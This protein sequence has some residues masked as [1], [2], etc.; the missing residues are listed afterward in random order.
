MTIV[1]AIVAL[2]I[3]VASLAF[4]IFQYRILHRVR[5]AEKATS[6]LRLVQ[7]L[8]RKSEDLRH[9]I[10]ST[11]NVDDCA[12]FFAKVNVF[13][14]EGVAK[15]ALSSERSLQELSELEQHMLSLELEI[16]L[17]NK[18]IVEVRR[19]NDE[20]RE[21]ERSKTNAAQHRDQD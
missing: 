2:V 6:L 8:R 14:E 16:D 5:T 7:E 3:S 15:L 20:V 19:F 11:D 1:T 13:L 21:Y 17:F 18:Q 12:E 4:S 10:N 9:M